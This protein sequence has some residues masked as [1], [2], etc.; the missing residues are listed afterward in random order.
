M[1]ENISSDP[2]EGQS[3]IIIRYPNAT[4][5]AEWSGSVIL[6]TI[7]TCSIL[8]L[9]ISVLPLFLKVKWIDFYAYLINLLLAN[10]LFNILASP[11]E[12]INNLYPV[13]WLP[14]ITCSFYLYVSWVLAYVPTYGHVLITANRLW[15]VTFPISYSRNATTRTAVIL[16][17]CS[18]MLAHIFVLPG[19]LFDRIY[20]KLPIDNDRCVVNVRTAPTSQGSWLLF[21]Q[22][23]CLVCELVI[24]FAYLYVWY[25]IKQNRR[26][27]LSKSMLIVSCRFGFSS[28]QR[29]QGKHSRVVNSGNSQTFTINTRDLK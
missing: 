9:N 16:C 26:V 15:A 13:W 17:I 20:Y 29:L 19:I 28:G 22:V 6:T 14:E 4:N 11:L 8:L 1:S 25:R 5:S 23:Q 10:I 27:H 3:V 12:I 7:V 21:L 2:L 24:I 18:W